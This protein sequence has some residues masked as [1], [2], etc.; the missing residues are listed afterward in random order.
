[1]LL[2]SLGF[3]VQGSGPVQPGFEPF[4]DAKADFCEIG[5]LIFVSAIE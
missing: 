3:K 4:F 1:M 2:S 5:Q